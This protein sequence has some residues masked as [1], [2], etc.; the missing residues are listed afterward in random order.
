MIGH[1]IDNFH[2]VKGFKPRSFNSYFEFA[3]AKRLKLVYM[4]V[5][6]VFASEI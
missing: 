2:A 3:D 6:A 5:F 1:F 4:V